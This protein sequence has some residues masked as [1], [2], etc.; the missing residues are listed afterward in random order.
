MKTKSVQTFQEIIAD[1][2][3]YFARESKNIA[4]G[5]EDIATA[6]E[7]KE[8]STAAKAKVRN[9]EIRKKMISKAIE[10]ITMV[11]MSHKEQITGI[12]SEPNTPGYTGPR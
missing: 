4:E 5:Y 10:N 7:N 12:V 11:A 2:E 1:L 6:K 9:S 8:D 3:Y